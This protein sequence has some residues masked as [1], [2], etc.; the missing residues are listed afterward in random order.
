MAPRN[1]IA[2]QWKNR[3]SLLFLLT[4]VVALKVWFLSV[5]ARTG[6][7][8]LLLVLRTEGE[9]DISSDCYV[10]AG[11]L[12]RLDG[13]DSWF[14]VGSWVFVDYVSIDLFLPVFAEEL[15]QAIIEA[16]ISFLPPSL[17]WSR[18]LLWLIKVTLRDCFSLVAK[19]AFS[20]PVSVPLLVFAKR[21]IAYY[22]FS[23]YL[24]L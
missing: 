13:I 23:Y 22:N 11:V 6:S 2:Q 8:D 5:C 21:M 3:W 4:E 15:G 10:F 14:N 1:I 9:A 12:S 18:L 19:I 7:Q 16:F 20:L 24:G 17:D